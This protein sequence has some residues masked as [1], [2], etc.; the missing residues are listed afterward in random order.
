MNSHCA[1]GLCA[2]AL[3]SIAA[4]PNNSVAEGNSLKDQLVGTWIYVSSTGTRQDGSA[5]QRPS[6]QGAVT[7]TADDRFHFITVRSDAPKYASSD[8]ARPSPEEAVAIA[9]G[10]V[11]YTGTYKV[12]ESNRTIHVNIETSSFPNLVGAPNQRRIVTSITGDELKFTNPRTPAGITLEL[13]FK[14]A[15]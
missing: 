3:I 8:P 6:L 13:V 15:K 12:D 7:Y 1:L 10:V 11:A 14:R 4:F 9:S 5:V 2:T